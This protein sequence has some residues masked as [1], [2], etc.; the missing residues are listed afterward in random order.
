MEGIRDKKVKVI[1]VIDR[2]DDVVRCIADVG[3][4]QPRSKLDLVCSH[5]QLIVKYSFDKR[6]DRGRERGETCTFVQQKAEEIKFSIR[7]S[8][9]EPGIPADATWCASSTDT[10]LIVPTNFLFLCRV[11][12]SRVRWPSN[13]MSCSGATIYTWQDRWTFYVI[14]ECQHCSSQY[15]WGCDAPPTSPYRQGYLHSQRLF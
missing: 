11:R 5:R 14:T 9:R 7:R 10:C 8:P 13:G 4:V 15:Y 1:E 2:I 6:G 3:S 12:P